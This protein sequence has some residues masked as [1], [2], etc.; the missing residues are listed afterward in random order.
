MQT[1]QTQSLQKPRWQLAIGLLITGSGSALLAQDLSQWM[2][3][4]VF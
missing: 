2:H 3:H 4:N 1:T